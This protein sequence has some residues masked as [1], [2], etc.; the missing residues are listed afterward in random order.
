[1]LETG[2]EIGTDVRVGE[3]IV[4][5]SVTNYVFNSVVNLE[6]PEQKLL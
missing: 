3:G 2:T 6:I 5:E 1:M 4:G